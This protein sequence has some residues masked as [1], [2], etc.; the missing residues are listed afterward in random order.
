[1]TNV[2]SNSGA[3]F[4]ITTGGNYNGNGLFNARPSFA[5][6]GFGGGMHMPMGMGGPGSPGRKSP[7]RNA[8]SL[9]VL[10]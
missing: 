3:P 2:N 5:T 6:A 4:N 9:P 7:H 10:K 8:A 1:M